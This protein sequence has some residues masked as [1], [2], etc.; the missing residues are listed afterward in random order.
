MGTKA[1][2][3]S[4][5]WLAAVQLKN[6]ITKYWRPRLNTRCASSTLPADAHVMQCRQDIPAPVEE[7]STRW[8]MVACVCVICRTMSGEEK[9]HLRRKLLDLIA[10]QDDQVVSGTYAY[11]NDLCH[12]M[13]LL[14][15]WQARRRCKSC[16]TGVVSCRSRR[17]LR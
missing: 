14:C 6:S 15:R 9:D 13:H 10:E 8:L 11:P 17:R 7:A 12:R 3:H 4:A 1:A 5:R 2:N 16:S